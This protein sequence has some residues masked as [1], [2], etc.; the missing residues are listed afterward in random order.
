M[1]LHILLPAVKP[2][3]PAPPTACPIPYCPGLLFRFNQAVVKPLPDT[4]YPQVAEIL[5]TD[6]GDGFKTVADAAGLAH[7]MCKAQVVRYTDQLI[8]ILWEVVVGDPD[9]SLG[10]LGSRRRRRI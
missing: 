9:G 5:V 2:A 4:R 7:Q 6:D 8:A 3:P 10:A 1:R